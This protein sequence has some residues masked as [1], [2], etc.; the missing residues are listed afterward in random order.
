MTGCRGTQDESNA[1]LS[2]KVA[3]D[4]KVAAVALYYYYPDNYYRPGPLQPFEVFLGHSF[5]DTHRSCGGRVDE[6]LDDNGIIFPLRCQIDLDGASVQGYS[7]VTL[8]Q[9]GPARIFGLSELVVYALSADPP[10]PPRSSAEVVRQ[11]Q[12]RYDNGKPREA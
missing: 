9:T 1:W 6:T 12:E 7:Y 11:I 5:G 3:P 10:P 4:T 8:R 2:V